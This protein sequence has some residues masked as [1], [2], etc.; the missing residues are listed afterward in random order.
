MQDTVRSLRSL[1]SRESGQFDGPSHRDRAPRGQLR[2]PAAASVN[3]PEARRPVP[4]IQMPGDKAAGDQDDR[5]FA[6]F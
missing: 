5:H 2:R 6:N 3:L 4:Q 1:V